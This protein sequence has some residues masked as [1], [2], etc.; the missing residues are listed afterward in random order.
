MRERLSGCPSQEERRA[1]KL[2]PLGPV[3]PHQALIQKVHDDKTDQS[4]ERTDEVSRDEWGWHN[5]SPPN[6]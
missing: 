2:F 1:A 5:A 4:Q 3:L 6:G